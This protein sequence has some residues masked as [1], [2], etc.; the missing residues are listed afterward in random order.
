MNK[1]VLKRVNFSEDYEQ[2]S[3]GPLKVNILN[4]SHSVNIL[5]K[6]HGPSKATEIN[7]HATIV[8]IEH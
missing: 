2:I 5:N 1:N 3:K 6:F 4:K 8:F 7:T